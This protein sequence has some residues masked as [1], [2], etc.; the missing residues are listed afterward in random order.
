M[1]ASKKATFDIYV[2]IIT[3]WH[4]VTSGIGSILYVAQ[5]EWAGFLPEA[6]TD[7]TLNLEEEMR[8]MPNIKSSAT[9]RFHK[10][11]NKLHHHPAP[12]LSDSGR[13]FIL[14]QLISFLGRE[15]KNFLQW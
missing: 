12:L 9:S 14:N 15:Y 7:Y 13:L 5:T 4:I 6:T 10:Q 1:L 2:V 8:N 11:L 3:R